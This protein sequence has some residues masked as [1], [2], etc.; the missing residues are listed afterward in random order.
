MI[1]LNNPLLPKRLLMPSKIQ[2]FLFSFFCLFLF[3]SLFLF[4]SFCLSF[5]SVTVFCFFFLF[6][7]QPILFCFPQT[8]LFCRFQPCSLTL[9]KSSLLSQHFVWK[10]QN[11]PHVKATNVLSHWKTNLT[12]NCHFAVKDHAAPCALWAFFSNQT[13]GSDMKWNFHTQTNVCCCLLA[14]FK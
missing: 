7:L 8:I 9:L 14:A 4:P 12:A 3:L 1:I 10:G 11:L 2:L 5:S 6:F 13:E